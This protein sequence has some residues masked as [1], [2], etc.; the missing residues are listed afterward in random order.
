MCSEWRREC[1][2][3]DQNAKSHH[4][5][6]RCRAVRW[7][8]PASTYEKVSI[9]AHRGVTGYE[10]IPLSTE[11]VITS[12]EWESMSVWADEGPLSDSQQ[13]SWVEFLGPS[14]HVRSN[15]ATTD[16]GRVAWTARLRVTEL[17][18]HEGLDLRRPVSVFI[19]DRSE[20]VT[21]FS[22]L[23]C[24]YALGETT[25]EAVKALMDEIVDEYHD[26][27]EHRTELASALRRRWAALR[28]LI[29]ERP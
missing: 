20:L 5:R 6:T 4:Q 25:E 28:R 22:P 7:W 21:A 29:V 18:G 19:D 1:E 17:E 9:T 24:L 13:S 10:E 26:L 2:T 3:D 14:T 27:G 23:L 15:D 8:L 12:F 16:A 11:A